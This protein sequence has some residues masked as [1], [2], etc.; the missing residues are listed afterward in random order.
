MSVFSLACKS[1]LPALIVAL[2]VRLAAG[3]WWQD[4]LPDDQRF[5]F[6]DSESYWV[7]ADRIASGEPYALNPDRRVFRTP[8]YPVLLAPLFVVVDG[9]P[10]VLWGRFLGAV[11]GTAAVA[12]A[13]ALAWVLF[14]RQSGVV[15]AWAAALYPEAVAMS[16]FVLSEAPFVP[17]MLMQLLLA[18]LAWRSDEPS[19]Q[20]RWAGL[21]G[22]TAGAATLMRPSWLLFTPLALMVACLDSHQRRRALRIGVWMLLGLTLAM[23]P[24]W[25]RNAWVTGHFVPTTLQVGES[26]YDGWNPQ[27]TGASDMQFVEEFRQRLRQEDAAPGV[28][29][30]GFD[31][32]FEQ[33]LDQRMRD[34]AWRWAAAHP[35]DAV[36]LAGVK[37]LRIWN[38]WPNEPSLAN[39]R[40]GLLVLVGYVPLLV[41]GVYGAWRWASAGWPYQLCFLPALYF[42]ALHMIFV[43]SI[44]YR[45]PAM[46]A[47][48]VLAA[49][50]VGT[51][52]SRRV[53]PSQEGSCR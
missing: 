18:T 12:A 16:T 20:S 46:V 25:I 36:R 15:A 40:F 35:M 45:Q 28:A 11:L 9:Q 2:L 31:R 21:A 50:V 4:R 10:P 23:S 19:R 52:W 37:F 34:A 17:L 24:W 3:V 51:W 48:L 1:I 49:G 47:L 44:R 6:P 14:G 43:G 53:P 13:A 7:L 41:V 30:R 27:A 38:V 22:L 33:R 5:G 8:G 39:W 32:S 29:E 26:L 42:T